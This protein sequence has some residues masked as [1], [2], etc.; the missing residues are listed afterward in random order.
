MRYVRTEGRIYLDHA[1]STPVRDEVVAAMAPYFGA[2]GFNASSPHA[3]GRVARAALEAARTSVARLL[4]AG[5]REIVFTGGG[6]EADN[7]AILGAARARRSEG[8]HVVTAATEHHAVLHAVDV[9]RDDGFAVSVLPVDAEGRVS[10]AEFAAALRPGTILASV[11]LAN[12]ELGT[13]APIAEL[14]ALARAR[15]V[16][17]H[18][19]AVQAPGRIPLDVRALG[20]DLVS[21][22]SH[23]FYGPKGVGALYVRA[24]TPLVPLIVGGGQE[25]GLR[26][27]TENVAGI[28]GFARALEF[29]VAELPGERVRLAAM[30]DRFEAELVRRLPG[31]TI[32]AANVRRLPNLSS[33]TFAGAP[34]NE[35]LVRLDLA[36]VAVS[37]GSACAAGSTQA[38][39]V[40]AALGIP[41]AAQRETLRFS[42][43]K[44]VQSA[45]VEPALELVIDATRALRVASGELG[46]MPIGAYAN[47]TG[48]QF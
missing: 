3:E 15:G 24:G 31:V 48:V 46:T 25:T 19:D 32:N 18:C 10:P 22:S 26:A 4:G 17:F 40:L 21:L 20:A 12:N 6:S 9:L 36:G 16:T 7:L 5:A 8:R 42:F 33:V 44:L 13:L 14:S 30:R 39:H 2:L 38:S 34:A 45:D 11:M 23:K 29:A 37:A 35:L 41:P 27:G 28:V 43:G 47:R 1:A